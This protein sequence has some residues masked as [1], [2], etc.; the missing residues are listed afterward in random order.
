M[1]GR[2]E[3]KPLGSFETRTVNEKRF[4]LSTSL[5]RNSA[6][7]PK[8]P[9]SSVGPAMTNNY[10]FVLNHKTTTSNQT[11]RVSQDKLYTKGLKSNVNLYQKA[12]PLTAQSNTATKL[13]SQNTAL[14]G[15]PT[16]SIKNSRL[17]NESS[18]SPNQTLPR[19]FMK[20]LTP[21]K[22]LAVRHKPKNNFFI[23]EDKNFPQQG[24]SLQAFKSRMEKM[25]ISQKEF[26]VEFENYLES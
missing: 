22:G 20:D 7:F 6:P 3:Y 10:G 12:R 1:L 2:G 25:L 17:M 5:P 15:T 11:P 19:P 18:Q 21:E 26:T 4:Q 23:D 8:R 16:D 13:T 14:L 24:S 9:E